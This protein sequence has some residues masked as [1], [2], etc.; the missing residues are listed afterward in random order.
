M[1]IRNLVNSC[2]LADFALP[3]FPGGSAFFTLSGD[4]HESALSPNVVFS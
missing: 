2:Q 3:L 1:T 4:R